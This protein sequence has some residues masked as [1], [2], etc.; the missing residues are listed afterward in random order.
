MWRR[1]A[2]DL[3]TL[4]A[5]PDVTFDV[6]R[7]G[8]EAPETKRPDA[9]GLVAFDRRDG[10][11]AQ[12]TM[13]I[14]ARADDGTVAMTAA[15]A[16]FPSSQSTEAG[17]VQ[18]D[19]PIYR[20][21]HHMMYRA[22]L[23]DGP[24]GALAVPSGTRTVKVNDP[25]GKAIL[26]VARTLDA[27]GTL[28]GEVPIADDAQLG[29]YHVVV[30]DDDHPV[31]GQFSVEAYKKPEYVV[32]VTAPANTVGGDAARFGVAARLLLRPS[33][34]RD[35]TALPCHLQILVLVVAPRRAVPVHGLR[36]P[37]TPIRCGV[38]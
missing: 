32:D 26:T 28:E 1:Y 36:R 37:G 13:L 6:Y 9:S 27:F 14:V 21:G 18:T 35:E 8:S 24:A 34:R 10:D 15:A 11:D 19:R 4:H 22:I 5:R 17:L 2:L 20:P 30:G 16:R 31:Y 29:L 3:R 12:G 7:S 25:S 33:R 38:G 23:R